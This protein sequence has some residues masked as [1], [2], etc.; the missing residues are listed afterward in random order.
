MLVLGWLMQLS[1]VLTSNQ[2]RLGLLRC[3]FKGK[4]ILHQ[5][6]KEI[7]KIEVMSVLF[8]VLILLMSL[9]TVSVVAEIRKQHI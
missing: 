9:A 6:L 7:N 5:K 4:S 8:I 2:V 1:L 3:V